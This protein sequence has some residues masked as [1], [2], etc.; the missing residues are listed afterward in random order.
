MPKVRSLFIALVALFATLAPATAVADGKH[1]PAIARERWP[2][3]LV[4]ANHEQQGLSGARN[5]GIAEC[6]GEVVA[7]LDDDA[8]PAP[9]WIERLGSDL[10]VVAQPAAP[11]AQSDA[12]AASAARKEER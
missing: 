2:D 9:N 4:V 3:A 12:S 8:T 10:L 11:A 6:G 1:G 5:T 7:F